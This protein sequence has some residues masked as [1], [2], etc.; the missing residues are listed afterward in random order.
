MVKFSTG[1]KDAHG[2]MYELVFPAGN[3]AGLRAG[4]RD[5]CVACSFVETDSA[6]KVT[7]FCKTCYAMWLDV[8]DYLRK[9]DLVNAHGRLLVGAYVQGYELKQATLDFSAKVPKCKEC[10]DTGRIA[11]LTTVVECKHLGD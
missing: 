7:V 2:K 6:S 8:A 10:K 11:L 5:G 3:P 4:S 1:I 9:H